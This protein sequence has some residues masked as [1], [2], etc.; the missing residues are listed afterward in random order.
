MTYCARV[1][2]GLDASRRPG[3]TE[4]YL[5]SAASCILTILSGLVTWPLRA[6][7]PFLTLSTTSMPDTTSPNRVYWPVSEAQPSKQMKNW[8]LAEFGSLERA[9]PTE[10]RLNGS[11]EN[12]AGMLGSFDPP[13]PV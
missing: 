9:M 5:A 1:G 13:V 2:S 4:R 6:A 8:L 11:R 7:S 3:M 12:S 10:P